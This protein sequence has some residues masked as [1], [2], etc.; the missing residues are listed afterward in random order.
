MN[1]FNEDDAKFESSQFT[2]VHKCIIRE[3]EHSVN[4]RGSEIITLKV[5]LEGRTDKEGNPKLIQLDPI[6]LTDGKTKSPSAN[7]ITALFCLLKANPNKLKKFK[8]ERYNFDTKMREPQVV[9]MYEEL[10]NKKVALFIQLRRIY[11]VKKVDPQTGYS[12][13]V[14]E[15]GIWIPDYSKDKRLSFFFIRAFDYNT[16][17]TYSELI[18]EKP[19]RIYLELSTKYSDYDEPRMMT[20]ELLEYIEKR[21]VKMGLPYNLEVFIEYINDYKEIEDIPELDTDNERVPF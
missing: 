19:A 4:D 13:N 12:V 15:K 18:S 2:G 8:V 7:K 3:A 14:N 5:E 20:P 11:R 17:Q 9:E 16:L 10:L 1:W 6:Y 21:A